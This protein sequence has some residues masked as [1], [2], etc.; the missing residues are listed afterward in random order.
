MKLAVGKSIF[1]MNLAGS[2]DIFM[3]VVE[4]C[5]LTSAASKEE[6]RSIL[7][8]LIQSSSKENLSENV[9]EIKLV[10]VT[11]RFWYCTHILAD[12]ES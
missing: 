7:Q 12:R 2:T 5:M 8:R 4:A 9:N 11:V 1:I 6:Q 10:Y 3:C